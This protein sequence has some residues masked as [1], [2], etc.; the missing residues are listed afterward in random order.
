MDRLDELKKRRLQSLES[1]QGYAYQESCRSAFWI[2]YFTQVKSADCGSCD[3]C[4]R[5][6]PEHS[7]SQIE[8]QIMQMLQAGKS[9]LHEIT[10]NFPLAQRKLFLEVLETLLD[11]GIIQKTESNQLIL[12]P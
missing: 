7:V 10:H 5:K 12:N 4:K 6:A 1:L 3:V 9:D 2:Q 8:I 11:K